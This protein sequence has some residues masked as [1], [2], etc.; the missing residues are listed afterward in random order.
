M[1]LAAGMGSRYG[2][3]KQIDPM[4]PNGETVLDYSVFDALRGG[5]GRVVFVIRK[6]FE[7][8]F[9]ASV[10]DK[11][12]DRIAVEYAFQSLD[13]L[14]AGFTVPAG[15]EKPWGTAHAILAARDVVDGP[16][17]VINA[18]DFY[19]QDSYAR[20]GAF[21]SGV[22]D[23]AAKAHFAMVGFQLKNTLSDFGSVARGICGVDA[24][25]YLESVVEMTKIHRAGGG[26]ENR[27]DGQEPRWP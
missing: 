4:G 16:F 18:D 8:A 23:D 15:R 27:E 3:L 17:A 20:L 25:G 22:R 10:G 14:P 19:G 7:A 26:A 13:D 24:A 5:F 11:F 1:V 21:L 6:D 12:S 2:G 9:R